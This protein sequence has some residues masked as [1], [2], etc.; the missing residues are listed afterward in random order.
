MSKFE[1]EDRGTQGYFLPE[2]SR[3]HLHTL[4]QHLASL[5]RLSPPRVDDEANGPEIEAL[6]LAGRMKR[7]AEQAQEVLDAMVGPVRLQADGR[8]VVV[9]TASGPG[10]DP[11]GDAL[12]RH[13]ES[14]AAQA[15]DFRFGM[16]MD[17]LDEANRLLDL[18]GAQGD[19]L[20]A[21][22]GG[23]LADGTVVVIGAAIFDGADAMK[24]MIHE[25]E[26]QRLAAKAGT[27]KR[28]REVPAGYDLNA[29]A[30][31]VQRERVR[32][33]VEPGAASVH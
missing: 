8:A 2:E 13:A 28:V 14:E 10:D 15:D 1:T 6:T 5:S 16:T 23:D 27:G 9:E 7:L 33:V 26:S 21:S 18:L 24:D 3:A 32:A 17:Q 30:S 19:L 4:Q 29:V 20:M 22:G 12:T 25:I 11:D 31:P